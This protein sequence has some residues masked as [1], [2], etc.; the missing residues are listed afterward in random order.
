MRRAPQKNPQPLLFAELRRE[1]A[2]R[3]ALAVDLAAFREFGKKTS[4][5][6]TVAEAANGRAVVDTFQNEFWTSGQRQGHALHEVSYRACFKPQL[7]A[8]FIERLSA[9]LDVVYD[10]FMG[11]GTTPLEAALLGRT[12]A[13]NDIN[14]L[15]AMLLRPRLSPPR[16]QEV[17]DRLRALDL[18]TDA[19][20]NGD[21]NG[22]LLA[23]YHP[24]TLRDLSSLRASLLA[25]Q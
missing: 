21:S 8:F 1:P 10:P 6:T 13:G 17:A 22:D 16:Q 25:R 4:Y 24:D 23:F 19:G 11:R 14:P 12:P 3:S 5:G 15:S 20:Q 18:D 7:P 9:P 2:G